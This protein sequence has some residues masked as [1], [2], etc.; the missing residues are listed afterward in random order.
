MLSAIHAVSI[1]VHQARLIIVV[2]DIYPRHQYKQT[3]NNSSSMYALI[4]VCPR[5]VIFQLLSRLLVYCVMQR[6]VAG[7]VSAAALASRSLLSSRRTVSA[8]FFNADM[9]AMYLLTYLLSYSSTPVK[10]QPRLLLILSS[11]SSSSPPAAVASVDAKEQF[12]C[13]C[14]DW[15]MS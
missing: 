13:I 10:N 15:S 2:I 1:I 12:S 9:H 11:F 8:L 7:I 6:R 4:G 5:T 3:Q 14:T